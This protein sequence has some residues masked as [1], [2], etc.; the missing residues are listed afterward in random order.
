[1]GHVSF[2]T[3]GAPA[4][5]TVAL[6]VAEVPM[7]GPEEW[8]HEFMTGPVE[9]LADLL[10][11]GDMLV[12]P[13]LVTPPLL[14]V[15]TMPPAQQR[16]CVGGGQSGG[17]DGGSEISRG[18]GSQG[19]RRE[20]GRAVAMATACRVEPYGASGISRFCRRMC[21]SYLRRPARAMRYCRIARAASNRSVSM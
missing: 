14:A 9:A 21:R 5:T 12:Q 17:R 4:G 19:G 2:S 3:N 13:P 10:G 15:R 16:R 6:E 11:G 1:M 18:G 8:A 7:T 20:V